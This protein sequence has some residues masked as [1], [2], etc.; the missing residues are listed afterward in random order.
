MKEDIIIVEVDLA[1][2]HSK[3]KKDMVEICPAGFARA[4]FL[5]LDFEKESIVNLFSLRM[6]TC[7]KKLLNLS[8]K[9][10]PSIL[11]QKLLMMRLNLFVY[12]LPVVVV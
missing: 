4:I 1:S 12:S 6:N 3:E 8:R 9:V 7:E 10:C 11:I 2:F 5:T